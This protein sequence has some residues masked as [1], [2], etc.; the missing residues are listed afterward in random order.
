MVLNSVF[1]APLPEVESFKR[2]L[3]SVFIANNLV[4]VLSCCKNVVMQPGA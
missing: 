3:A 4:I 2:D 1:D